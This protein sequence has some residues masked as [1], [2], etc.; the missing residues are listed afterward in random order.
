MD[1]AFIVNDIL[2]CIHFGLALQEICVAML[3]GG[4]MN[5][6]RNAINPIIATLGGIFGPIAVYFVLT[7]IFHSADVYGNIP[8]ADHATCG[9]DALVEHHRR[10]GGSTQPAIL[11]NHTTSY[12]GNEPYRWDIVSQV[13]YL[14]AWTCAQTCAWTCA[15]A[16]AWTCAQACA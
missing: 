15:Q 10:R 3:P 8:I 9:V 4:A 7:K 6:I 1:L 5:P 2:M 16:C 14:D 12:L 13:S 11:G